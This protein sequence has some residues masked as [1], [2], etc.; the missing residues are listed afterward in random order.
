MKYVVIV[1][2]LALLVY[3]VVDFN[4]RSEELNRLRAEEEE[5]QFQLEG[6]QATRDALAA[7]VAY[8]TSEAA[9]Y[10]WAYNNHMAQP[11]DIIVIPAQVTQA[12]PVPQ[13]PPVIVQEK[14]SNFDH[15]LALFFDP[16]E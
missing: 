16:V 6:R 4:H 12:T 1:V 14:L 9:V 7:Q 2:S 13:P 3:L 8:A 15:W 10:D 11:G 5:V